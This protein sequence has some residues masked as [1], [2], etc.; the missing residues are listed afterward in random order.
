M[1][2][3]LGRRVG[4]VH[5]GNFKEKDYEISVYYYRFGDGNQPFFGL[6]DKM[7]LLLAILLGF[8]HSLAIAV[9]PELR[10]ETFTI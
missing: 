10:I 3:G 2:L 5:Q 9:V 4:F 1:R 8:Q 7:P 6:N